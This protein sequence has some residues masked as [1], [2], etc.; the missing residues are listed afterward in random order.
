[1]KKLLGLKINLLLAIALIVVA[2]GGTVVVDNTLFDKN[3]T[4]YSQD[5][6]TDEDL[7]ELAVK[8]SMTVEKGEILPLVSLTEGEEFATFNE[9]GKVLLF[10]FHKYP[11]SYPDGEKVTLEWG[12]VWTFTGGELADWYKDNK[13]VE[14]LPHRLRQLIG[15]TPDNQATHFTAFWV[16]LEDLKRP[17]NVQEVGK[18]T[19]T[20]ALAEGTDEEFKG[21][22]DANML[23]SYFYGAYPWTRLGYTYD[24]SGLEDEYGLSEFIIAAGSEVEVAYTVTTD[25]MAG[26][27]LDGSW[28][29]K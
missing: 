10:T 19:M 4:E 1:M 18:V 15:L 7:F 16:D 13:E 6:L 8:D 5:K 23:D 28:E 9:D 29:V 26:K 20:D 27:L 25:D 22:Y 11:D 12:E 24:W 2:I 14:D 21:W 3:D 17:A